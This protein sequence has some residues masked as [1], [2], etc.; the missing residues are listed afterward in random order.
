V[1]CLYCVGED[2]RVKRQDIFV[3]LKRHLASLS[4]SRSKVTEL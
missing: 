1:P 2:I 4:G 3:F